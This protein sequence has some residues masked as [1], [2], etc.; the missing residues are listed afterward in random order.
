MTR[1]KCNRP[2]GAPAAARGYETALG[3]LRRRRDKGGGA[4]L[5]QPQ[6]EAGERLAADFGHAQLMPRTT[7]NWTATAPGVRSRRS[8][9]GAGVE[10]SDA[11]VAARQRVC[12]AL[13]A[14]GPELSGMLID[15]C[16]FD[17][18]LEAVG[19]TAGWRRGTARV[20]LDLA[21][22][23]LA[24]HYGLI[25]PEP[26]AFARLRRWGEADYRPTLDRWR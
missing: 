10:M 13:D 20:V 6:F 19:Q 7:A 17:L 4:L 9:P 5:T 16:C 22:T 1:V 26:P 2:R 3:W 11:A 18:G 25:A 15:V 8:A 23:R 24:R 12:R 14:V 21:L